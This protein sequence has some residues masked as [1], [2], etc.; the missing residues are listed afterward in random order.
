[1]INQGFRR[2]A[3]TRRLV[4][5]AVVV[6]V[7]GGAGYYFLQA[8]AEGGPV[9]YRFGTVERGTITNVVSSTGKVTAV[10]EVKISSQVAGQV[11]EVM[12]DYNTPVTV[13]QILAKLDPEAFLSKVA[14]AEADLAIS[15]ASLVSN[16]ASVERSQSDLRNGDASLQSLQAQLNNSRLALESAERDYNLQRELYARNVVATKAVDDSTTKYEQAKTNFEQV[17]ANVAG[18]IATQDGR[19]ASLAQSNASVT[20]AE[21]QVKQR[22][23]QLASAK[24]E[25]E[26]TVIKAPVN[27]TVIDRT[28]EVGQTIQNNSNAPLFT[29]AQDL[30]QMQ[31]EVSVDEADIGK[32]Q[33]GMAIKFNVDAFP[34]REFQATVRQVRLA[35][36]TVQ[37]VVTY[38]IIAQAPNQDLSLLPGMTATARVI[39]EERAAAMRIPNSALRYT[40]AGFVAPVAATPAAGGG[41]A[42]AQGG[43]QGGQAAAQAGGQGNR[44]PQAAAGGGNAQAAAGGANA[45]GQGGARAAQAGGGQGGQGGQGGAAGA[46]LAQLAQLGLTDAQQQTITQ[47]IT[48]ARTQAQAG[49]GT[50]QEIQQRV[51]ASQR[52][53]IVAALTPEQRTR[54]EA[55]EQ[56]PAAAPGGA[57]GAAG[58]GGQAAAPVAAADVRTLTAGGARN[59]ASRARA[60]RVFILGPDGKPVAVSVMIG[61]TDGGF[62]EMVQGDLQPGTKVITGSNEVAAAAPAANANNPLGGVFGGGGGGGAGPQVFLK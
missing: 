40:P 45:A 55:L 47:A 38:T 61:I 27:G 50:A 62:T 14:Q 49:G 33:Q 37:N 39:I 20:T 24:I 58:G 59:A 5:G 51:Q 31:L 57:V 21:A 53:A 26:R 12:A 15:R 36:K 10:G 9:E 8:R 6:V 19:K 28:A 35:P 17:T 32:I 60:A 48:A 25:L 7:A 23:A 22:E 3:W 1:M 11:I 54:F 43:G 18:S 13:G 42:V 56:Q 4:Q 46:Q 34:G 29:V 44:N 41:Q 2:G 52:A 30:R 16:K